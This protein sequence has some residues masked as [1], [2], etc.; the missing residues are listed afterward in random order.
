MPSRTEASI[1]VVALVAVAASRGSQRDQCKL[2]RNEPA[3]L[4]HI[5]KRHQQKQTHGIAELGQHGDQWHARVPGKSCAITA[6]MGW[7]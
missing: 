7:L 6:S 4:D 1:K 2:P 5:A 3:A